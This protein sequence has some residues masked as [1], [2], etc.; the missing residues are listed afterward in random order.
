[1]CITNDFHAILALTFPAGWVTLKPDVKYAEWRDNDMKTSHA[2]ERAVPVSGRLTT[3]VLTALTAAILCVVGP[4]VIP[5]GPVP[6]SVLTLMLYL[7]VYILDVGY[8]TL[9]CLLYLLIGLAGLPVFSG[10]AGGFGKLAGPTGGYLIGYIPLVLIGG[11]VVSWS[12]NRHKKTSEAGVGEEGVGTRT[13]RGHVLVKR[14]LQVSGLILATVVLY[15]LGT[16][17][18]VISSGTPV[19]AALMICV[20]PFLP[21]DAIKIVCAVTVGPEIRRLMRL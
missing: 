10:A 16:V 9:A 18:F 1:M 11:C 12:E 14:I 21:G 6:L 8:A 13:R 19:G 20:V 7:S 17:W 15:T 3:M 2:N 4:L 5:I